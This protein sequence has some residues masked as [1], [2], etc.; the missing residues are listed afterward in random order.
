[1]FDALC[2][3]PTLVI[4]GRL[5]AFAQTNPESPL[6]LRRTLRDS[7]FASGKCRPRPGM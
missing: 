3:R 2:A 6:V 4:P 5:R 7:G 1:M